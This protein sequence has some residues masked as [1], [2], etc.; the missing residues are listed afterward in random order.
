MAF[1]LLQSK[2][3]QGQ[4]SPTAM[5]FTSSV[6]V[7]SLLVG[8]MW[9]DG[10]TT[11][12]TVTDPNNGTWTAIGSPTTGAGGLT[13]YRRQMFYVASAV[14]GSTTVTVTLSAAGSVAVAIH[15]YS[16]TS[17]PPAIDGT[18][19]YDNTFSATPTTS[20]IVT[21]ADADLLFA[22][23]VNT[24][25][26]GT[27]GGGYIRREVYGSE[28]QATEDDTDGGTAG[29]KTASFS[30]PNDDNM[31]GFVAF[32]ETAAGPPPVYPTLYDYS[33]F[34]KAKLARVR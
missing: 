17:S 27:A 22:M 31:L 34:P 11:T 25:G 8:A 18:P 32:K 33:K 20:A 16:V 7:G 9:W 12:C 26:G 13:G 6:T 28:L 4:A 24:T 30:T 15:E 10:A 14:A 5:T 2:S 23:D 19:V 3:L 29:S 21:T 1:A